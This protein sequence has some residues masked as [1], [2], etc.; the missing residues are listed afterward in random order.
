MA[1]SDSA[2]LQVVNTVNIR[3]AASSQESQRR[4]HEVIRAIYSAAN[5]NAAIP[6]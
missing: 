2:R 4:E 1:R 6:P 5:A 3:E